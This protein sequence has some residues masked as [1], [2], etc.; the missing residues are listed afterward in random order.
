[1]LVLHC[2]KFR[3]FMNH[4]LRYTCSFSSGNNAGKAIS[5]RNLSLF[6][7]NC[8]PKEEDST[9]SKSK[10]KPFTP[11]GKLNSDKEC[12]YYGSNVMKG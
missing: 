9:I 12:S 4:F 3:M 1:M 6:A 7:W 8:S 11:T 10:K 2:I 5:V